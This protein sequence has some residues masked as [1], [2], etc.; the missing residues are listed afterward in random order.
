M[1]AV[2]E[3]YTYTVNYD[4]NGGM[5]APSAQ[6]KKYGTALTLSN[7]VPT[8]DNFDFYGW[9]TTSDGEVEYLPGETYSKNADITLFAVW[10][11][12]IHAWNNGVITIQL[13]LF[14]HL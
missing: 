3:V 6:T 14:S 9:A 12:H 10:G 13:L 7:A 4:A 8:R 5:N 1:Y 2:W 11:E